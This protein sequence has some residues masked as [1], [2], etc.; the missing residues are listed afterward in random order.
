MQSDPYGSSK[1]GF[2]NLDWIQ[3]AHRKF[4]GGVFPNILNLW[5]P[6]KLLSVRMLT[7]H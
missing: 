7:L 5:I 6:C 2:E 4:S 3:L 1:I